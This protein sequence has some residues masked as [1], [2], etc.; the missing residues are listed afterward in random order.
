MFQAASFLSR[1]SGLFRDGKDFMK[2]AKVCLSDAHEI[3]TSVCHE[4]A[5]E[6][7]D[8]GISEESGQIS[9]RYLI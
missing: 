7:Y 3:H 4:A 6:L 5:D 2:G 8:S 9:V 1:G